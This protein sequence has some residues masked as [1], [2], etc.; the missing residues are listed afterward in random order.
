[1]ENLLV[2]LGLPLVFYLDRRYDFFTLSFGLIFLFFTFHS[3]GTHYTYAEMPLF[4]WI[5]HLF[6]LSRNHYDR[7]VHFLFGFLLFQPMFECFYKAGHSSR[8]ASFLT[9]CLLI[10][11][12]SLYEILEWLVVIMVY[13]ELG[14]QFLGIQGDEWDSQKDHA[15]G[16]LGALIAYEINRR[17]VV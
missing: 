7:V 1:M 17:M 16:S 14:A 13:P 8:T 15:L 3:I 5:A 9:L 12:S 11:L 6:G 4:H 2:F 10:A